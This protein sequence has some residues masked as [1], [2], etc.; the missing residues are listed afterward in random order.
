MHD[1]AFTPLTD[2][3]KATQDSVR[4]DFPAWDA[5]VLIYGIFFLPVFL[6]ILIGHNILVWSHTR[7]NYTFIFGK[8][9]SVY[10]PACCSSKQASMHG[11]V[12]TIESTSRYGPLLL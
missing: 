5:L 8:F 3:H 4:D 11:R 10:L 7:I 9:G 12:L 1:L 6:A 2:R